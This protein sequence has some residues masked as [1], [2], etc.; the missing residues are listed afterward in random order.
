MKT[1]ILVLTSLLL[2]TV[3]GFNCGSDSSTACT[4]GD[5]KECACLSD[6]RQLQPEQRGNQITA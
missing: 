2:V 5:Q 3:A 1:M 6:R 4:P